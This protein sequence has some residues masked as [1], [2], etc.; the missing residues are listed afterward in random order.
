MYSINIAFVNV[1]GIKVYSM[2][3]IK[4]TILLDLDGVINVYTKG[5][6]KDYIPPVKKGAENFLINLSQ[7]F[8]IKLFTTREKSMVKTWLS[9]NGLDKYFS[10]ITNIKEAC[11]LIVDDRCIKF[12]GDYD[13]L[14]SDIM[15]FHVWHEKLEH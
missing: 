5:F 6:C 3:Y 9:D 15:N 4:K 10:G 8:K 12:N 2:S 11:W 14:L 1:I 13:E 7:K